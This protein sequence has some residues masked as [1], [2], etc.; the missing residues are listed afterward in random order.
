MALHA[1]IDF[2]IRIVVPLVSDSYLAP[3]QN[4]SA[5]IPVGILAHSILE[6]SL[7]WDRIFIGRA[8]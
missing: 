6:W 2:L 3:K 4:Q 7:S 5:L 1:D 8:F